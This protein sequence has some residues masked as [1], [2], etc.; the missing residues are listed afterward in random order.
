[1]EIRTLEQLAQQL[2]SLYPTRYSHFEN[3][4]ARPFIVYLDQGEENFHADNLVHTEGILVD[5]ELYTDTKDLAAERRIKDLFRDNEVPYS[6]SDTIFI[7]DESLYM[8]VFTIKLL[9]NY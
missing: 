1:M 2:N 6:K 8:T 5:V 7:Q 9:N 3:H 4:Q